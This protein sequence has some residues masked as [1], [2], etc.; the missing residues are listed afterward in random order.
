MC[1][2]LETQPTWVQCIEAYTADTF[3][4]RETRQWGTGY[5]HQGAIR[6]RELITC[7][8]MEGKSFAGYYSW[9]RCVADEV[10]VFPGHSP[11]CEETRLKMVI[12]MG[13]MDEELVQR[14]ILRCFLLSP[15]WCENLP[16]L[17]SHQECNHSHS[18]S[19]WTGLSCDNIPESQETEGTCKDGPSCSNYKPC[20]CLPV[21][22]RTAWCKTVPS[23]SDYGSW[24][25]M[26]FI[27][28]TS[29]FP[30]N[31][32]HCR[33]CFHFGH[34]NLC[35]KMQRKERTRTLN[36]ELPEVTEHLSILSSDRSA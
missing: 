10:H 4:Y 35:C 29:K 22:C 18:H 8:Q 19:T 31:K 28:H 16:V 20:R 15:R 2:S 11:V 24:V 33:L 12:L 3:S 1:L 27:S 23:C 32:T 17:L 25:W 30:A 6:Q 5:L 21:L 36:M 9:L 34:Y 13:V 26:S 7:K 14:L